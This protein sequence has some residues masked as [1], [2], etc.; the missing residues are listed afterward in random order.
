MS[1]RDS[2]S[3][4]EIRELLAGAHDRRLSS[5]LA[6]FA[7]DDR[8][9]VRSVVACATARLESARRE[10]K[11]TAGM[12]ALEAEL[13]DRGCTIVA[14]IDEVGRGALAGPLTAAAVVLRPEPR[15]E[16]LDDSKRLTP[17]RRVELD[18]IIRESAVAVCV[19]HVS[20]RDLDS[21]GM[22]AALR[23]AM[24]EAVGGLG[25]DVDHVVVDGLPVGVT[26]NE[27]AVIK[28]DGKVAAIAAASIVAKV[29]RDA[30]MRSF[31]VEYPGYGF[32]INKGYG[33]PEHLGC[34]AARGLCSIHRR[35]FS[36]G[37]GTGS[38][39]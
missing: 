34:I 37:G 29:T 26:D 3:V 27:T 23:R 10:R 39:F 12:Y 16:G 14:G 1:P 15:I 6:R 30:L 13:R 24:R 22:T 28:G 25:I 19:A 8:T 17:Q 20:A 5:L 32:E 35:S 21:L 2:L 11:R 4:A 31:A 9:G 38:L 7:G 33:T 36:I 18:A